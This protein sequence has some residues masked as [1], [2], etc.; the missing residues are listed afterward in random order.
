MNKR[1]LI[2]DMLAMSMMISGIAL[3]AV[4]IKTSKKVKDLEKQ[5]QQLEQEIE[6]LQKENESLQD[7]LDENGL[8]VE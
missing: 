1:R 6:S 2:S 7:I 4:A 3:V 5:E 8:T